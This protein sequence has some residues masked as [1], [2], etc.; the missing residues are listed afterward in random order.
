MPNNMDVHDVLVIYAKVIAATH[1]YV[2]INVMI[3]GMVVDELREKY[4]DHRVVYLG[5]GGGDFCPSLRLECV[6]SFTLLHRTF[7]PY[8][9]DIGLVISY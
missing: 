6:S 5:D 1:R 7:R 4:A 2:T 8:I 3:I 9:D